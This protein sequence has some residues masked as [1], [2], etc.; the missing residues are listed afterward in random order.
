MSR[1][2]SGLYRSRQELERVRAAEFTAS[3]GFWRELAEEPQLPMFD[4]IQ[5]GLGSSKNE[6]GDALERLKKRITP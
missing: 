4:G 2:S 5:R 1:L 3:L 6:D